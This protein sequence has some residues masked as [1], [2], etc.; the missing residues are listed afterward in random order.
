[1]KE[2]APGLTQIS[3]C[4]TSDHVATE[5]QLEETTGANLGDVSVMLYH[6]KTPEFLRTIIHEADDADVVVCS[7]SYCISAIHRH[8]DKPIIYESHNVEYLLKQQMYDHDKCSDILQHVYDYESLACRVATN[9]TVCSKEDGDKL[10]ELYNT[11][12]DI[13]VVPNGTDTQ[14][15]P[16]RK[17]KNDKDVIN[18]F[19]CCRDNESEL[20]EML[21]KL[22]IIERETPQYQFRYYIVENDSTDTT[23]AQIQDFFT[24]STGEYSTE[25]T[26]NV[27][28]GAEAEAAR[29]RD[30]SYYRNKM[31]NL[32][33]DWSDSNYSFII[34]T[35]VTFSTKIVEQFIKVMESN[36]GV[37]MA[38]PYGVC[39]I[40]G[41]YYDLY[42]LKMLNG[43][44]GRE[45]LG[46]G[47]EIEISRD[48]ITKVDSAFAGFVCIQT[49]VL[50]QC[51]WSVWS[52]DYSE[53]VPFCLQVKQH[54]DVIITP[55][56]NVTWSK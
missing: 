2:I 37:A 9:I 10:R 33:S 41:R 22:K 52:G 15:I 42:A 55:S 27:K 40:T 13:V 17:S 32:C 11:K 25:I 20:P 6:E 39:S 14:S 28:W 8:I 46:R 35:G 31:K 30:M 34:D 21:G 51:E 29:V 54:G 47:A 49:D 50:R 56:V 16:V 38:T 12:T 26:S 19:M 4:K 24:Y 45:L 3:I 1:M 7:H 23:P 53:H 5:M 48:N 18:M 44:G 43:S 36:P